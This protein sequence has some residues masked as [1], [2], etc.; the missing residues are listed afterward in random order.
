ML[1]QGPT[2]TW[3][4][5]RS[6]DKYLRSTRTPW[7]MLP[8]RPSTH[9][10]SY[11]L[12]LLFCPALTDTLTSLF[13]VLQFLGMQLCVQLPTL[14]HILTYL[15]SHPLIYPSP[16]HPSTVH[17]SVCHS[18]THLSIHPSSIPPSTYYPSIHPSII[19]PSS[20]HPSIHHRPIIQSSICVFP[21]HASIHPSIHLSISLFFHSLARH[22]FILPSLQQFTHHPSI[23]RPSLH[24]GAT[25]AAPGLGKQ[26]LLSEMSESG[27]I[28]RAKAFISHHLHTLD[29]KGLWEGGS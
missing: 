28:P 24:Q 3:A 5:I 10:P 22:P 1:L 27:P 11:P 20:T 6:F 29:A 17:S 7:T 8:I 14:S 13:L 25:A 23:V 12:F 26:G 9:L 16:F 15:F 21:I 2:S 19:H 4:L 18:Y